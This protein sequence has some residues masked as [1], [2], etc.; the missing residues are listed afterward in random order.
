MMP[1]NELGG[2]RQVTLDLPEDL[3]RYLGEDDRAVSRAAMEALALEGVRS[4]KLSTAQARVCSGF[5]P[6]IR[7][8]LFSSFMA[9]ITR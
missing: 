8:M 4:G 5:A 6:G 3:A 7:W 2:T 9:W 1:D